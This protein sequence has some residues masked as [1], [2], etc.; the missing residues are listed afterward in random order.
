MLGDYF[1]AI[2][3]NR[4]GNVLTLAWIEQNN[5][6]ANVA[7]WNNRSYARSNDEAL[8]AGEHYEDLVEAQNWLVP[9]SLSI[10][11][12]ADADVR[13]VFFDYSLTLRDSA[14]ANWRVGVAADAPPLSPPVIT[15]QPLDQTVTAPNP[16]TFDVAAT[17]N[18]SPD[19]QWQELI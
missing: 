17:G 14:A 13:G 1:N 4:S 3:E 5:S 11:N 19:Y 18:P 8:G 7:T 10:V 15:L 16:A 2:S 12:P 6:N 9:A